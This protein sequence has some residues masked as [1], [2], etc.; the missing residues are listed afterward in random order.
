MRG[1]ARQFIFWVCV[2]VLGGCVRPSPALFPTVEPRI[3]GGIQV[4]VKPIVTAGFRS[5]DER[6]WG[7]DFSDYY[8]AFEVHV[9]NG[10]DKPISIHPAMSE[11]TDDQ[12]TVLLPLDERESIAHYRARDRYRPRT[13][14]PGY[15]TR[16]DDE[17]QRIILNRL[18][19]ETL[20][21]GAKTEGILYFK[22]V[23]PRHCEKMTLEFK[24]IKVVGSGA[25]K[26]LSFPFSCAP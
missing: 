8:T 15:R 6:K 17:V 19:A 10:T 21:P 16:L 23:N 11:L 20:N 18:V 5:E 14:L 24:E 13:F 22:K 1:R 26:G 4:S 12:G 25:S 7:V 2:I 3:A 9:K